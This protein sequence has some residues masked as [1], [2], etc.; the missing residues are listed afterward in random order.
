VQSF[1]ATRPLF[2]AADASYHSKCYKKVTKPKNFKWIDLQLIERLNGWYE[3]FDRVSFF[4][5]LRKC[6][7]WAVEETVTQK[8]WGWSFQTTPLGGSMDPLNKHTSS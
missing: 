6:F 5:K 7:Y 2:H 8:R 1:C 4:R 3:S